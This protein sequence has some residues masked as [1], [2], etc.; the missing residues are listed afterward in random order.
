MPKLRCGLCMDVT[1][2]DCGR[3]DETIWLVP[4]ISYL[5]ATPEP[6]AHPTVQRLLEQWQEHLRQHH[7]VACDWPFRREE[8]PL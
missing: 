6:T 4:A 8:C 2:G 1:S 7:G 5:T 3:H